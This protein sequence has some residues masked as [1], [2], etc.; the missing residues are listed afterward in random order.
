VIRNLLI[1]W[2]AMAL[3]FAVTSWLLSGMS[4]SGGV[5]TY[6]WVSLLFGIVNAIPGTLIRIVSAPLTF[7][8]L[9]LFGI[10]VNA[11]L[12]AITD[13]LTSHLTIDAFFWTTIVAA[14]IL[15]VVAVVVHAILNA[16]LGGTRAAA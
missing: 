9:G 4:V 12:L 8:T 5:G 15:A 16:L 2:A 1:S 3:A 13:A 11:A 6:L 14:V 7:L 10:V